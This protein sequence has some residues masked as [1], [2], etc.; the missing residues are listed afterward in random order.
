MIF[1]PTGL[2][3]LDGMMLPGNGWPVSG[4]LIVTGT[5]P[6]VTAEKSPF[7]SA[8]VGTRNEF[9]CGWLLT[10]FSPA[11]QKTVLFLRIGPPNPP[12]PFFHSSGTFFWPWS[13]GISNWLLS[14]VAR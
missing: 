2:M 4:S 5:P 7:F 9:C 8:S 14:E 3:R 10:Y 13:F 11:D 12:P 6:R 1:E